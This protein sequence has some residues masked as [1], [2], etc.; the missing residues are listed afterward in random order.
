MGKYSLRPKIKKSSKDF[1]D[2]KS[3]ISKS[4]FPT[5]VGFPISSQIATECSGS[6]AEALHR[7]VREAENSLADCFLKYW[8]PVSSACRVSCSQTSRNF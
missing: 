7:K 4:Q 3:Q 1:E 6:P 8:V 5:D 2:V